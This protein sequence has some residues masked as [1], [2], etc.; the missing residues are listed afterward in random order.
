MPANWAPSI[1][2]HKDEYIG[3]SKDFSALYKAKHGSDPADFVAACGANNVVVYAQAAAKAKTINDP[4][5]MLKTMRGFE[6]E[7]FFGPVRYNDLGLNVAGKI[8]AAQFQAGKIQL[9]YPPEVRE[10]KP[11]HPYPGAKKA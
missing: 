11:V 1:T 6:G 2:V 8:Y 10:S 7:T 4:A 3:T 9:V 5:V